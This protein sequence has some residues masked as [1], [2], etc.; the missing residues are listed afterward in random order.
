M[1]YYWPV[2]LSN[3]DAL[4]GYDAKQAAATMQGRYHYSIEG[5]LL[6]CAVQEGGK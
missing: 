2:E 3:G 1:G 5:T 4:D 6:F